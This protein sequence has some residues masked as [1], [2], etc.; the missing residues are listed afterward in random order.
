MYT[1][2]KLSNSQVSALQQF[3][4]REGLKLVALTD[5]ALKAKPLD[6]K[7]VA[8]IKEFEQKLGACVVAVQ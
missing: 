7:K 1:F 6:E 3:E 5:L 8:A 4:E 2:A